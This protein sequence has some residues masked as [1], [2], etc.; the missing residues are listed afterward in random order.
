MEIMF[1]PIICLLLFLF[2]AHCWAITH[3]QELIVHFSYDDHN[4][5]QAAER[6]LTKFLSNIDLD[7]DHLFVVSGHTDDDGSTD[8]N[9]GLARQRAEAVRAYLTG[10]GI[11]KDAI[12]V[13]SFGEHD[14]LVKNISKEDHRLNRRVTLVFEQYVHEDIDDLEKKFGKFNSTVF[15]IDPGKQ[16]FLRGKYDCIVK[17]PSNAFTTAH[18]DQVTGRVEVQMTEA[19][20][21]DQFVASGLSTITDDGRMLIS[22]GMLQIKAFNKEGQ[23]LELR[24]GQELT[25][26]IPA[27]Q[28]Q[29]GMELFVSNTGDTWE[30][31]G[32]KAQ[33]TPKLDLPKRPVRL[34]E[35]FI[36]PKFKPDLASKPRGPIRPVRPKKP[37]QPRKESYNSSTKWYQLFS[38]NKKKARETLRYHAAVARYEEKYDLYEQKVEQYKAD[39][40][41]TPNKKEAYKAELDTWYQQNEA[42][43][44]A[45]IQNV[46]IPLRNERMEQD[47]VR[48]GTYE[49]EMQAWQ[50]A[51]DSIMDK[52]GARL[53]SLGLAD[54]N[55]MNR[56]IFQAN[57]MGW[58]NCDRF[59]DVPQAQKFD[60]VVKDRDEHEEKVYVVF[61][62]IKS[63]MRLY[64]EG[65][66]GYKVNNIPK[67]EPAV[68]FAYQVVDGKSL[69]CYQPMRPGG[70]NELEFKPAKFSEIRALLREL[71]AGVS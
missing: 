33:E 30:S 58:I 26:S 24:E 18:G 66:K 29:P 39:L 68:V 8:Y 53:D 35:E 17:V 1:R 43:S 45:Y 4:L 7:S 67:N 16:H 38:K 25:I 32:Q 49:Q 70:K 50:A 28:R 64:P 62:K 40:R 6:A 54:V 51:C 27:A 69:L 12:T 3:Q 37:T 42:D 2:N 71:N 14:P 11:P 46:L 31:T 13:H 5:D 34:Y 44:L 63:M 19:L 15:Q 65:N 41:S 57:R 23:A 55:N 36:Y 47:L 22:G 9:D 21:M 10:N 48:K 52:Y 61:T 59:Y 20:A 56:Y 60:L